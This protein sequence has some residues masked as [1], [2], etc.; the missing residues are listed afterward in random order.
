MK[1]AGILVPLFSIPSR[2]SW[3]IGEIPDV[4]TLAAWMRSARLEFVQLLPVTDMDEGLDSPY[5]GRS[6]MAIDPVYIAPA[7]LADFAAAGGE[8]ALPAECRE[9]L[10]TARRSSKVEYKAVRAAKR[11]ALRAA[12]AA[13]DSHG[14]SG[15][16]ETF[17]QFAAEQAWWLDD[18]ALFRALHDENGG[19][20]WREWDDGVRDRRT[21]ALDDARRRLGQEIRFHAYVQWL[22]DVQW[23]AARAEAGVAI[24]GDFPFMVSGHS[25]DVWARQ[26]EF[27]LDA[28]VGVPPDATSPDGQD[29]GLP[30]CRWDACAAGGYEWLR[31]RTRRT[32]ALYDGFRVDHLVGFYRTFVR[33]RDGSAAFVP[34]HEEDQR[35]QGE[36]LLGIFS[37]SGATIVAEDL[38]TVP[39]FVR[40]SLAR[41]GIP[42]MKVLRWER[43]WEQPAQPFRDPAS[44][45]SASVATTGTHDTETLAQWWD[46]ASRDERAL[47]A[48][49]PAMQRAGLDPDAPFSAPVRDGL[50]RGLLQAGSDFVI[51]PIQDVFGWRD[52]INDPADRSGRNWTWRLPWPVEDLTAEPEAVERA[53]FLRALHP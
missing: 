23:H 2:E 32:A 35:R 37:G 17:A 27:R 24:F 3:G 47:C 26:H 22:A 8:D 31:Q 49:V 38:G 11:A 16:H 45:P 30:A 43:E 34:A 7:R 19:R 41:L 51:L 48:S 10:E 13:F 53:A 46:Q 42:G 9:A 12:F 36:S 33:E 15:R 40:A 50:L 4:A 6:A 5:A 14:G 1:R 39:D 25:A 52:R 44:Y 29:W 21:G 28:S 18:Y 20:Y